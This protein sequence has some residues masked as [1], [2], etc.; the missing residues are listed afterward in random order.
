MD[1]DQTRLFESS[2]RAKTFSPPE[3]K[4]GRPITRHS[5]AQQ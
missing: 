2:A 3:A 1:L 4:N 5:P